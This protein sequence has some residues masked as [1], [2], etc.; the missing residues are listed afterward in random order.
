MHISLL[1]LKNVKSAY[2]VK[3]LDLARQQA[4]TTTYAREAFTSDDLV[5]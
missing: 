3:V 5:K 2:Y 1:A 4:L